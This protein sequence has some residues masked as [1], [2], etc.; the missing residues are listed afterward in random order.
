LGAARDDAGAALSEA[1][2]SDAL[3]AQAET[4]LARTDAA[5]LEA[6][7]EAALLNRQLRDLR[8]QMAEI[9]DLLTLSEARGQAAQG[10]VAA[11]TGELDVAM[12]RIAAEE[13]ARADLEA[14]ERARLEAE[15]REL[16]A[17]RSEFFQRLS[18][19]LEGREG[20]EVVGDRFVFSSEVLFDTGAATLQP[21]GRAQIAEL[22]Q[23]ILDVAGQIPPEVDWVLRVDGHTDDIPLS[24]T[25]R[26]RDNWELSQG[27]AL[28]VVRYLSDELGVPPDR[29]AATGFGQYRPIDPAP[30]P[31][32]RARNRRIELK[33]TER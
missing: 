27:R 16:R 8:D 32:A 26:F 25:G 31:E 6:Q 4:R 14:A 21:E 7:R 23:L 19:V 12:T 28:S 22:A 5:R 1:E 24:G 10:E 33:L 30:T 13:R 3:L 20:V 9:R 17:Y 2:R 18:Q 11:L 29:L 15:A